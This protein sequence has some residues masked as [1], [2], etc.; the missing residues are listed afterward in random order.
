LPPPSRDA[1][2]LIGLARSQSDLTYFGISQYTETHV[3]L[4]TLSRPHAAKHSDWYFQAC[5]NRAVKSTGIEK[6]RRAQK[7]TFAT[8]S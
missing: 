6:E 5:I 7:E 2:R 4:I 8:V 1:S 3:F